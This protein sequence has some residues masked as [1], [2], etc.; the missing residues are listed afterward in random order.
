MCSQL[1]HD[2]LANQIEKE[3]KKQPPSLWPVRGPRVSWS[4]EGPAQVR[5]VHTCGCEEVNA[6]PAG[7]SQLLSSPR[8]ILGSVLGSEFSSH[9]YIKSPYEESHFSWLKGNLTPANFS[10][11]FSFGTIRRVF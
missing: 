4:R 6:F 9:N 1:K 11:L 8:L 10:R 7:S 3:G 2:W 5:A